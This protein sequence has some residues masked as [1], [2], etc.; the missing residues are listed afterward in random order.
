MPNEVTV[1]AVRRW[2]LERVAPT[3]PWRETWK[4][5]FDGRFDSNGIQTDGQ[6]T[7]GLHWSRNNSESLGLS[8]SNAADGPVEITLVRRSNA[9]MPCQ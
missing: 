6:D 2:Y 4:P 8:A 5:C 7:L 1:T 3:S 9:E